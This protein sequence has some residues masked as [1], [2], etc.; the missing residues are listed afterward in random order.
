MLE[1]LFDAVYGS[2]A[3]SVEIKDINI[4]SASTSSANDIG[5]LLVEYVFN[6]GKMNIEKIPG[7][8]K[9]VSGLESKLKSDFRENLRKAEP[10]S[11]F[12]SLRR[13]AFE[14]LNADGQGSVDSQS[15]DPYNEAIMNRA[16]TSFRIDTVQNQSKKEVSL[17]FHLEDRKVPKG[18]FEGLRSGFKPPSDVVV[19]IVGLNVTNHKTTTEDDRLMMIPTNERSYAHAILTENGSVSYNMEDQGLPI[20]FKRSISPV[21]RHHYNPANRDRLVFWGFSDGISIVPRNVERTIN[22]FI[23]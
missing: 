18:D 11:A 5:D 8:S 16:I 17:K 13:K 1:S 4:K 21:N 22:D 20:I 12:T 23:S 14:N 7:Y 3:K 10:V 9:V 2:L 6:K 15:R 19:S